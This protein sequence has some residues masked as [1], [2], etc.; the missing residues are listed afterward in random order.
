MRNETRTTTE[1]GAVDILS[2]AFN[3][4]S[5]RRRLAPANADI[6]HLR[7]HWGRI[8]PVLQQ[9]LLAGTYRLSPMRVVGFDRHAVWSAQDALVLKWVA[10]QV[11]PLL[12]VHA[13]CEHV[14]GHGGGRV[15][16]TRLSAA[17]QSG[18]YRYVCRTDIKGYYGNITK[19]KVI[20][21]VKRH[22]ADPVLLGLI[23]QYLHY[24]VEAGGEFYT[25]KQGICRGCP[26][27]PLIGAMHLY[28]VDTHFA[29]EQEKRGIVYARYM[30][31][32]IILSKSRWQLRGQ[33]KALNGYLQAYGFVQHPDKTF[34]GRVEKGFDWM[35]AWLG[36]N[37]VED[38]APRALANHREKV[39]RLYERLRMWP[40]ARAHARV[41]QY[42]TRWKIWAAFLSTFTA[43]LWSSAGVCGAW[44]TH[45]VED[46]YPCKPVR[47]LRWD[48]GGA[49]SLPWFYTFSGGVRAVSG[50]NGGPAPVPDL[51]IVVTSSS[52]SVPSGGTAFSACPN[53]GT[54][55]G[56]PTADGHAILALQIDGGQ[57][58]NISTDWSFDNGDGHSS[59]SI[60]QFGQF[61][62]LDR[63]GPEWTPTPYTAYY[64]WPS[65]V[66]GGYNR[67]A[68][69]YSTSNHLDLYL[70]WDGKGST[71]G[72][73]SQTRYSIPAGVFRGSDYKS[74]VGP[75]YPYVGDLPNP[76]VDVMLYQ[77]PPNCSIDPRLNPS[78]DLGVLS[79]PSC[80]GV[81]CRPTT[82]GPSASSDFAIHCD[83]GSNPDD[84]E[85]AVVRPRLDVS[86]PTDVRN[87]PYLLTTSLGPQLAIWGSSVDGE[88]PGCDL[89]SDPGSGAV[90]LKDGAVSFA[91]DRTWLPFPK[92]HA[93]PTAPWGATP[94]TMGPGG[95][96]SDT[97]HVHWGLCANPSLGTLSAGTFTASATVSLVVP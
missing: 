64:T 22:I 56:M 13:R 9:Q 61:V 37:G 20:E 49:P 55:Y 3:W 14:A 6:W 38:I 47:V 17:L 63:T 58:V 41:S 52:V 23:D 25:P 75:D 40:R 8:A 21:Q 71:T 16:V 57:S 46:L 97:A 45:P 89:A 88:N 11:A 15:S 59:F 79:L 70:I 53:L 18:K 67:S 86:G 73:D 96:T 42:R 90:A 12:P 2:A 62:G 27:S 44:T 26:L 80:T 84:W 10:L 33:V 4:V 32:F 28:E 54:I 81:G 31:D 5:H 1:A 50:W 65:Q 74:G 24:T 95:W 78:I 83:P 29:R 7:Y 34:I 85:L 87:G 92:V 91:P 19:K 68:S 48:G 35:G 51:P 82:L 77:R 76:A 72:G 66:F 39:R 60:M 36:T 69:S 43:S 30:D 93:D 94:G